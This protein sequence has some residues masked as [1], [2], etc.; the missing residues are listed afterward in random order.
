[1]IIRTIFFD[2]GGVIVQ[3]PHDRWM[4][5][6]KKVLGVKDH[7]EILDMLEN[8]HDSQLVKDICL[9]KLPENHLWMLMAEKWH[10]RPAMINF[11]RR[12]L[13]SKRQLNQAIVAFMDELHGP[14]QTAILSNA[15]DQTRRLLEET[16]QLLPYVDEIIISAE[17]GVIKPDPQIFTIAMARLGTT[18][19]T[20]LL[21]DDHLANVTAAREFGMHAVQF[22]NSHQAIDLVRSHLNGRYS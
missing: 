6:W 5:L 9:G 8:P 1:M 3:Q 7:P 2:F 21:L 20:S 16:Y 13:F 17:E 19:E 11:F 10:L 14:Y 15:G 12:W 22:I 4:N 18:P